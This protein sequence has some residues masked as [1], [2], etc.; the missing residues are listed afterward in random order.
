MRVGLFGGSF[1]PIHRG[2]LEPVQEARRDLGLDRVI[3]LP[4]ALPPH[5]PRRRHASPWAR[6]AMVELALLA[7]EGLFASAFELTLDRPAYT[8]DTVEHFRRE[9]PEAELHLLV[10]GDSFADLPQ[11][12]RWRDIVAAVHLAV[13]ARP[14]WD[15]EGEAALP[16]ELAELVRGGRVKL[17][18]QPPVA[19]SSTLLR[20]LL[21]RGEPPP[22]GW[23]PDL[24]LDFIR[25]YDLYR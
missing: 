24:V 17:L 4:T 23:L 14:G 7:E 11:W 5:K 21:A 6:Y 15:L 2:H 3:Y 9:L 18:C 25:K 22:A 1:D 8:I 10:G 20:E 13:L 12:F 16:A 19:V